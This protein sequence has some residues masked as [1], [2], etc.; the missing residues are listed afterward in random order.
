MNGVPLIAEWP[1]VHHALWLVLGVQSRT[2]RHKG[3]DPR[4]TEEKGFWEGGA[5]NSKFPE[6]NVQGEGQELRQTEDKG[7]MREGLTHGES[8][9]EI[10]LQ[11]GSES[12]QDLPV[13]GMEMD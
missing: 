7:Q 13:S 3:E 6:H 4:G 5:R 1:C 10:K 11:M 2:V 9:E 8:S 12:Q